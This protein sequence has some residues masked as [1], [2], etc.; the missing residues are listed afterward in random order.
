MSVWC[1]M[2]S[3]YFCPAGLLAS[4]GIQTFWVRGPS[5]A[6]EQGRVSK[7][8][9]FVSEDMQKANLQTVNSILKCNL[10]RARER[11]R[12]SKSTTRT[13][14]RTSYQGIFSIPF[15]CLYLVA[16]SRSGPLDWT[17]MRGIMEKQEVSRYSK[18]AG[19]IH[20]WEVERTRT[21]RFL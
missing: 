11:E 5:A 13:H 6:K 15:V 3:I 19:Q 20:T 14:F 4:C 10:G 9:V 21:L 16:A 12:E 8:H 17:P 1:G 18:H 7:P 2:W